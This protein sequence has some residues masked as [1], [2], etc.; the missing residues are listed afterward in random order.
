MFYHVNE[1]IAVHR[2]IQL[3]G[4]RPL[5][6][7]FTPTDASSSGHGAYLFELMTLSNVGEMVFECGACKIRGSIVMMLQ[8]KRMLTVLHQADG[9]DANV[10]RGS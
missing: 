7:Q 3:L 6:V 4:E 8:F 10:R 1:G 2:S 5:A 9:Q